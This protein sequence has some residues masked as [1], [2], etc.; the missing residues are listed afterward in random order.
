MNRLEELVDC[1]CQ[2]IG[3]LQPPGHAPGREGSGPELTPDARKQLGVQGRLRDKLRCL[4]VMI[5]NLF[6][7]GLSVWENLDVKHRLDDALKL[8]EDFFREWK[9][10]SRWHDLVH[11]AA[12]LK[13][14]SRNAFS[15]TGILKSLMILGLRQLGGEATSRNLIRYIHDN[16]MNDTIR[17]RL[18]PAQH[19][20]EGSIQSNIG[21]YAEHTGRKDGRGVAWTLKAKYK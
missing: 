5:A 20:W 3:L 7:K 1:L 18:N 2:G 13:E 15:E 4:C 19:I 6:D 11:A 16:L 10:Q 9:V 14:D 17:A 21:R 12:R 8:M